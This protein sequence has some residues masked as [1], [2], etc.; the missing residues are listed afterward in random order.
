[1]EDIN[2]II[3]I[4]YNYLNT[5]SFE[6]DKRGEGVTREKRRELFFCCQSCCIDRVYHMIDERLARQQS[7]IESDFSRVASLSSS[8]RAFD[9]YFF[10]MTKCLAQSR[11][12]RLLCYRSRVR[13]LH[14][15]N[16]CMAYRHL[17]RV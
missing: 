1:M 2:I 3:I 11:S 15:T 10:I 6:V 17:F 14:V 16:I 7:D 8:Q 5:W 9:W 4:L 13:F 12:Y